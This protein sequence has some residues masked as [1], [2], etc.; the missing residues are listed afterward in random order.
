MYP[1]L[2][3][4]TANRMLALIAISPIMRRFALPGT[5]GLMLFG[6]GFWQETLWLKIVGLL[7][8]APVFWVC[9]VLIFVYLPMAL[10]DALRRTRRGAE[11]ASRP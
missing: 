5:V 10:F 6:V 8:A 1:H 4:K 2:S 9:F 3:E 11:R 7:L